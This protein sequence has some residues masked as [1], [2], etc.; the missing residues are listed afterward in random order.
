MKSAKNTE[1]TISPEL[2]MLQVNRH[3]RDWRRISWK[4]TCSLY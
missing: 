3:Y 2:A 1:T 4:L